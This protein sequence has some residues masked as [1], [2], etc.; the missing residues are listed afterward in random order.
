MSYLE[1]RREFEA[2]VARVRPYVR[3]ALVLA[4]LAGFVVLFWIV[5]AEAAAQHGPQTA[6]DFH[7]QETYLRD[8]A[9]EAERIEH[10][11]TT[12]EN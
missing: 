12:A 7:R 8:H 1:E 10:D 11:R 9:L 4:V 2:L 3:A 5:V 6:E